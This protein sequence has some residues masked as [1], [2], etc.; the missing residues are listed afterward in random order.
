MH[1]ETGLSQGTHVRTT[2][3]ARMNTPAKAPTVTVTV[4]IDA[5]DVLGECP[6]WDVQRNGL[7]WADLKRRRISFWDGKLTRTWNVAGGVGS[8]ALC[9]DGTLLVVGDRVRFF[10]PNASA[11]RE[12]TVWLELPAGTPVGARGNDGRVDRR[13]RYWV[14]TMDNAEEKRVGA[15]Y[16]LTPDGWSDPLWADVGIPNAHCF[17]PDGTTAYWGDSWDQAVYR[18]PL[19]PVTGMPGAREKIATSEPAFVD[20]ACV[21]A[22]GNLW[23]CEWAGSRVVRL[24]PDGT[25]LAVITLP[26]K[27][28]TC[29]AFGGPDLGTLFVTT[30]SINLDPADP[31][32]GEQSGSVLSIDVGKAWGVYGLPESRFTRA[33]PN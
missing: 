18:M 12:W 26:A 6:I 5:H 8:F 17:S 14:G 10:D 7:W 25:Q 30:A 20:G 15:N 4:A 32:G 9:G 31:S 24:A 1:R 13:G 23:V 19:D 16:V 27:Q 28:P 2:I 29:P 33:Q 21:D 22:D 11:G 3:S